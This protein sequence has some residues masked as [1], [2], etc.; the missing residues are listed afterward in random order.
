M[1]TCRVCGIDVR[2][3]DD[4]VIVGDAT[5]HSGCVEAHHPPKRR[6]IRSWLAMGSGG[7]MAIGAAQRD[8]D[9]D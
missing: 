3:S 5:M 7:Q 2:E 8:T 4:S 9:T 1:S 6:R